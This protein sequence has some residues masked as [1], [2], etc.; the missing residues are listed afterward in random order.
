MQVTLLDEPFSVNFGFNSNVQVGGSLYHVQ[1]EARASGPPLIDTTVYA[2]GRVLHRRTTS[3]QDLVHTDGLSDSTLRQRVENQH[4]KV[5]EEL[6]S[7]LI[8]FDL[9]GTAP[10]AAG[11]KVRLLNAGSWLVSGKASLKIGVVSL[12]N[13]RPAAGVPVEV[14]LEGALDPVH[15][16]AR[17]DSQGCAELG[18]VMPHV[19]S[20]GAAL[21]IRAA[22]PSG[23]DEIRYQ[24]R[25]KAPAPPPRHR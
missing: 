1:T 10:A 20:S 13:R 18:F 12:E 23:T 24:V 6:N 14:T 7:G 16:T 2:Q 19:G 17:T 5:I 21:V 9:P 22:G 25:P 3:Y 8:K 15:L 4:R 11:L